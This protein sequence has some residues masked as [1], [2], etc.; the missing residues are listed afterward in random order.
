VAEKVVPAVQLA[1]NP[2][3]A[4]ARMAAW[5]TQHETTIR[6]FLGKR[7]GPRVLQRT[8]LDDLFQETVTVAMRRATCCE[9]EDDSGFL[10]WIH[11]IARHVVLG[12]LSDQRFRPSHLRIK[13]AH[14]TGI[15]V[16]E[17]DLSTG[18]RTPSSVAAGHENR[19][20]V[21]QA[22]AE[23][24]PQYQRVIS[25]YRLE[26]LSLQEVSER[27]GRSKGATCRLFARAME[28]LTA[29]LVRK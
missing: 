15:G 22:L 6:R 16:R 28:R 3:P 4:A 9:A 23:L 18:R 25:L 13:G 26:G 21:Q 17:G 27:M 19:D 2:E 7:S 5:I 12:S 20:A 24:P 10:L 8:T 11:S 14:S 1:E 29:I